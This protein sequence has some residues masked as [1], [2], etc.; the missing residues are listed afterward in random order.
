MEV[1][2]KDVARLAGVSDAV[3]S[4]VLNGGPRGVSSDKAERVRRAVEKL[5][6]RP[7]SVARALRLQRSNALG[8]IIPD[9]ANP[10]FAELSRAVEEAAYERGY[11]LLIGNSLDFIHGLFFIAARTS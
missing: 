8:L 3:V 7:N 10:Y 4:Y 1:T 5:Q 2:R 6:Y 11:I 9:A